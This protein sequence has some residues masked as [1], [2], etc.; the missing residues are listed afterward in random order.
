MCQLDLTELYEITTI[1]STD[2]KF[3]VLDISKRASR[4]I[5]LAKLRATFVFAT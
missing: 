5:I 4:A 2:I 1:A 3:D